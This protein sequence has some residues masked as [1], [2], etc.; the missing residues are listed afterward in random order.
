MK[1]KEENNK[2]ILILEAGDPVTLREIKEKMRPEW[3]MSIQDITDFKVTP[4]NDDF[5]CKDGILYLANMLSL[6]AVP[7]AKEGNIVIPDTVIDIYSEA[8]WLSAAKGVVIPGSVCRINSYAFN[9]CQKLRKVELKEGIMVIGEKAFCYCPNIDYMTIPGSVYK[10][11]DSAFDLSVLK[12]LKFADSDKMLSIGDGAFQYCGVKN[13]EVSNRNMVIQRDNFK[14]VKS[15][16][17]P[18]TQDGI[19]QIPDLL[20]AMIASLH[21]KLRSKVDELKRKGCYGA[22]RMEIGSSVIYFPKVFMIQD[23]KALMGKVNKICYGSFGSVKDKINMLKDL[24]LSVYP[25]TM[26]DTT[27]E[28]VTN[29]YRSM[30]NGERKSKEGKKLAKY[31]KKNSFDILK[32]FIVYEDGKKF[33]EFKAFLDLGLSSKEALEKALELADKH[34]QGNVMVKAYLLEA[35]KTAKEENEEDF[36]V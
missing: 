36:E 8:F 3:H 4:D 11:E 31:I 34:S 10:I 7:P 20:D 2:T 6:I 32:A 13:L 21:V 30:R 15:V 18:A 14:K 28:V 33:N 16:K 5:V 26:L 19:M 12:Y 1:L 9:N 27:G 29:I 35:I 17:V 24:S 23:K 22:L 25:E